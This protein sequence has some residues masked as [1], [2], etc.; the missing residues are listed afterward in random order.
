MKPEPIVEVLADALGNEAWPAPL[1]RFSGDRRRLRELLEP[2]LAKPESEN[3]VARTALILGSLVLGEAAERVFRHLYEAQLST[4]EIQL[5]DL[6]EHRHDTDYRLLNGQG[7][8]LYRLNIKFHGSLF[9]NAKQV[10]GLEPE[11]CFALATYKIRSAL[12]KQD[13]EHLP[14]IFIVVTGSDISAEKVAETLPSSFV[15]AA[16][17]GKKLISTG[18]RAL[19]ERIV[20][21]FIADE[22]EKFTQITDLIRM[23]RW[24]VFSARRAEEVMKANLFERVYALRTRSF[25]RAYRNAEIDM[26]LSFTTDMMPLQQFLAMIASEGHFK[27]AGMLERG[28]I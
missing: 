21:R 10:V 25:N 7:R 19:E 14:Y 4:T 16:H 13:E 28:T 5:V 3:E 2:L 20:A 26:H 17:Y 24:Y 8:P 22:A 27:L 18:K 11:D 9:R 12:E 6:R 23:A 1:R 15:L